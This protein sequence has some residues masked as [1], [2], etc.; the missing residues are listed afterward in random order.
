LGA[1]AATWKAFTP[2]QRNA[3]TARVAQEKGQYEREITAWKQLK[4]SLQKPPTAYGLFIR[5]RWDEIRRAGGTHRDVAQVGQAA[6]RDWATMA[7]EDKRLFYD[8]RRHMMTKYREHIGQLGNGGTIQQNW[9][10]QAFEETELYRVQQEQ[11]TRAARAA[12]AEAEE[13]DESDDDDD[14]VDFLVA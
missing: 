2:E 4:K 7:A 9:M 14:D 3:F 1:A 6:S 5:Q 11:A 13:I 8:A 10:T 12:V